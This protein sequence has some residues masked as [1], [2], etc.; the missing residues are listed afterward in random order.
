MNDA[1]K[2]LLASAFPEAA[3]KLSDTEV[4]AAKCR[5]IV[6]DDHHRVSARAY[7]PHL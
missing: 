2:L 5:Q 7:N 1:E 4:S 6:G 3:R